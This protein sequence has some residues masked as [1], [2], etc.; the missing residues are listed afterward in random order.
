MKQLKYG[1]GVEVE[2][3]FDQA[4]SLVTAGLREEGFGVLTGIDVSKTMKESSVPSC[5]FT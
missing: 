3:P 5:P 1:F 4:Q 2:L